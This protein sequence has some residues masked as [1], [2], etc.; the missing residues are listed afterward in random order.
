M[1]KLFP[2]IKGLCELYGFMQLNG[3]YI[4]EY[5][6]GHAAYI[7]LGHTVEEW[8]NEDT[9]KCSRTTPISIKS[10]VQPLLTFTSLET[11]RDE[12]PEWFV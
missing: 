1:Y 10:E 8:L 11:I 7:N 9:K 4:L 12:C 2:C 6:N 3:A 5:P